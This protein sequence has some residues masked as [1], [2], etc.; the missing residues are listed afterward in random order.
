M[1]QSNIKPNIGIIEISEGEVRER[2]QR[3]YLKIK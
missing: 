1:N 2:G 3:A